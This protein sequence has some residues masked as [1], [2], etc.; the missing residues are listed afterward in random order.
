VIE[1]GVRARVL[2]LRTREL[3]KELE[4]TKKS[5]DIE[6]SCKASVESL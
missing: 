4:K 2:V 1:S 6:Q 5:Y 3:C